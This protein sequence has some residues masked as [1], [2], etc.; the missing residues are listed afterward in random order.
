MASAGLSR[1][2]EKVDAYPPLSEMSDAQRGEFQE[3]LLDA[4]ASEDLLG[5]WQAAGSHGRSGAAAPRRRR[6]RLGQP[7]Y[8]R[9]AS[10]RS[11][12]AALS[13]SRG[14]RSKAAT[15]SFSS[16][17]VARS[18]QNKLANRG[19]GHRYRDRPRRGRIRRLRTHPSPSSSR[20][21]SRPRRKLGGSLP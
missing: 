10:R 9:H 12:A 3:S 1:R 14:S 17:K 5:K 19:A 20:T 11:S 13:G 16:V 4:D 8:H 15:A 21:R 6:R 18:H 2:V 7:A